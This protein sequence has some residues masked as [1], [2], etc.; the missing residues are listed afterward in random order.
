MIGLI[1]A[2]VL[3]NKMLSKIRTKIFDVDSLIYLIDFVEISYFP[4]VKSPLIP[5]IILRTLAS[6]IYLKYSSD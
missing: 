3:T 5:T 4:E 6:V 2:Y 1:E